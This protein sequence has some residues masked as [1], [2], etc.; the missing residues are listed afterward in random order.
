M[1][2][3][4]LIVVI[5]SNV[6]LWSYQM[7]QLDWEKAQENTTI[8][9]VESVRDIWPYNPNEYTLG[10]STSWLSGG[11]PN[12]MLDDGVYMNFKSYFSGT[13]ISD[14]VDG[15]SNV[16][17]SV[18]R[19]T[20]SN[21]TEQQ[22]G[23]DSIYDTLTEE[24]TTTNLLV[25]YGTFTKTTVVGAQAITGVGF[26][27][28][29]VIFWWTRQTS[30]GELAGISTGY[31]FATNYSGA[32]QNRAVA[33]ALNDAAASSV[34]GRRRSDTYSVIILSSGTPALGAQASVTALNNDG[35]VLNWQTNEARA[36]VCHYVAFGGS[37]LT[38]TRA[39]SFNL[40]TG[41]GTQDITSVGFQ[42]NFVMFLWTS[43]EAVDT[44]AAHA[45]VGM[46]LAVSATKRSAIVANSEDGRLTIDTWQQQRTDSCIL[47]LDPANGGQDAIV[48]F[49]QFLAD[50]F[51]L[52][53]SDGPSASTPIFYLALK[54]GEYDTGSFDSSTTAG[55]QDITGVGFQ[56]KL[57]M[58]ATQGRSAST[59]V[60]STAELTLGASA[61]STE[62]GVA[63][64]EDPD[65]LA[66]SDNEM[67][68]LN[69]TIVSW[70]DRTAANTFTLRGSADFASFLPN[71][72]RLNW[73]SV[74]A[75]GRQILYVAFGGRNYDLDLEVQWSSANFVQPSEY[76]CI[77]TSVLGSEPLKVDVWTGG[78]WATIIDALTASDWN[79]VSV[80][81]YLTS[82]T[83]TIRFR[84]A[85]N[86]GDAA[87]D[88]WEID[89][90]MLHVWYGEYS[91]EIEFSGL[92]NTENWNQL[93]WMTNMAWTVD[94]VNV[95]VQLYNFAL[96]AYP[97]GGSGYLA[98]T[99]NGT[100]NTDENKSQTVNLN[101]TYF[102]N[103]TGFWK[104]KIT[105]VKATDTQ[106]DFKADW[107]EYE[108][109]K[110]VGTFFTFKNTGSTTSFIV[111]L[112]VI[113]STVHQRF[114]MNI[115][116]NSGETVSLVNNEIFLPTD[117]CIVKITTKRGNAAIFQRD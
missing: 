109:E 70:R 38:A 43:T 4:I 83:F 107:I 14:F 73:T 82:S 62:R 51:R 49:S 20:H 32:Y 27:P 22:H 46:G 87:Q 96:D 54:G 33:F 114:D 56:P 24:K 116:V 61:S 10:G 89:V 100:P 26:L 93:N 75:T 80:S 65:A 34:A 90:T 53:K 8:V 101:P 108:A 13:D 111:S 7:N 106:F 66:D 113:D 74:E 17:S 60:G 15:M 25:K 52:S 86:T 48:D 40:A 85:T 6:V 94:S 77:K 68:T 98:Y 92:S 99:S 3:L 71:G 95:T 112:W 11:I 45:E 2:S 79:N 102:R 115:F 55:T 42:P 1:L 103:A 47:L 67:E 105:G 63:W 36:D 30:Y 76:L 57:L 104:M 16:D 5:V 110:D 18:D 23:P 21:F 28:K 59:S 117:G 81:S 29:A 69:A 88:Q 35:F 50:G 97:T 9:N 84:D 12:L 44:N 31:G 58:L 41:I 37:D 72:F 78:G 19:G 64:F 39:G 91:S